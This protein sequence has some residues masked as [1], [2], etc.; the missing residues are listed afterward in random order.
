MNIAAFESTGFDGILGR[1]DKA[2]DSGCQTGG[3]GGKHGSNGTH[4]PIEAEFAQREEGLTGI[5]KYSSPAKHGQGDRQI[6][7]GPFFPE[8]GGG[9]AHKDPVEGKLKA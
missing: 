9:E 4:R 3:N 2:L 8:T 6:I 7:G 5:R 1:N